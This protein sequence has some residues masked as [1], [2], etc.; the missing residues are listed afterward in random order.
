MVAESSSRTHSTATNKPKEEEEE[1]ETIDDVKISDLL[2]LELMNAEIIPPSPNRSDSAF[3]WLPDFVGFSWIAYG[4]SSLL[5]ISHLP[6]P[7][8]KEESL[9]RPFFRQVVELSSDESVLVKAV[10]WSPSF[11]SNG[12]LAAVVENCV[13]LYSENSRITDGSFRWVHVGILLHS[14]TVDTIKW[15]G[16]GDGIIAVGVDVAMWKRNSQTWEIVWKFKEELPQ[17]LVSTTWSIEG[18]A[19]TAAY[20]GA[21]SNEDSSSLPYGASKCVLVFQNDEKH[22]AVRAELHHPQPVS[23]IQ[24]RP[25][26]RTLSKKDILHSEKD[27]LLTCCLDGTVRL[28]SEIDSGRAKKS[29]KDA[30]D[31]KHIRRSFH[32]TAVIEIN[33]LLNGTLGRDI[34]VTW[35]VELRGLINTDEGAKQ[36][37]SSGKENNQPGKCEWLIGFGPGI[38]LSFWAIHCL[39]DISP[40]RFPRVILWKRQLLVGTEVSHLHCP[41]HSNA[42][43]LPLFTKAVT[44]R[45]HFCGP[46]VICSLVQLLPCNSASWLQLFTPPST[47]MD[48]GSLEWSGKEK[49]L[50]CSACGVLCLDG[51]SGRILQIALH[52]Y[53]CELELAV[54]LDSN[55]VLLFWSLSTISSCSLGMAMVGHHS[56]K[57]VG[58]TLIQN[59]SCFDY[60][61]LRWAPSVLNEYRVLLMGHSKGIDCFIIK[62]SGSEEEKIL[63]HRLCTIP[64]FGHSRSDAPTNI[65]AI[66]FP[67]DCG[68][69]FMFDNFLLVGVW[70]KEFQALSWKVT[71]LCK[72]L[73]ESSCDCSFDTKNGAWIYENDFDGKRYYVVAAPCSSKLPDPH[74]HDQVMSVA[75]VC[76]GTLMPYVQQNWSSPTG[77]C[78]QYAAYHMATGCLDGSLKLWR[79]GP[80]T[81]TTPNLEWAFS[82]WE[83]VGM[84]YVHPG[85]INALS[86]SNCGR[87]VATI[88]KASHSDNVSTLHIWDSVC[89]IG[90]GNFLAEDNICLDGDVIALNWLALGNGQLLLGVCMQNELRVYA[91]KRCGRHSLVKSGKSLDMH[92]WFC[93]ASARTSPA[94]EG[95]LWGPRATPIIVHEKYFCHFSQWSFHVDKKYRAKCHRKCSEDNPHHCQDGEDTGMLSAIFTDCG[96]CNVEELSIDER[97]EGCN[98]LFPG[99]KSVTIDYLFNNYFLTMAKQQYSLTSK[100]GWWNMLEVAKKLSGSLPIYN[101]EALLLNIYSGKWKHAYIAIRHL[102]GYLKSDNASVTCQNGN[103]HTRPSHII[104]QIHL[105]KYFEELFSTSLGDKGFQWGGDASVVSSSVQFEKSPT[106]F[107]GYY[108]TVNSTNDMFTYPSAKSEINS[109]IET[110]EKC[111]DSVG[112]NDIEKIQMLALID[113]LGEISGSCSSA[114]DSLD[115][116]GQRFWV[117]LRFQQ[118]Y[119]LRRFGRPASAEDLVVDSGLIGWAFHSDCQENLFSSCLSNEPSWQEMRNLGVG[120]WFTNSTELRTRME[121]LARIQYLK[122]KDPKDCALLYVALNRLQ[123]LA[124]LFKISRD[125]RDKPMVGF[126][127]RNFQEEKNKAAALKNAYVL[128]GKHQMEL[129]IA[130]FLLGGEPSS[131]VTICAKNL[132]DE[133]LALVICRLLEGFGGPLECHLTSTFLLPAAFEKQDYW[134]SSLLEWTLGNYPQSFLSLLGFKT[135]LALNKSNLLSNYAAFLDPN[136]GH[137]CLMLTS[138]RRMRNSVGENVAAKLARWATWMTANALNRCGLPLEALEWLSS[139]SSTPEDKDEGSVD[140]GNL[141]ILHRLLKSSTNDAS[142]WL[143][144]DVAFHLES[145]AKLDLAIQY[146]SGLIMEHP[147]WQD[148][149]LRSNQALAHPREYEAHQFKL[150]HE[151]F[152]LKLNTGLAIFEQKYA[153]NTLDLIKMML[154]FSGN[155]GLPFL[156]YQILHG[157]TSQG[158]QQDDFNNFLSFCIIPTLILKASVQVCY[159]VARNIMAWSIL[160]SQLTPSSSK[161]D[162]YGG[163]RSDELC[164]WNSYVT[165]PMRSLS[166]TLQIYCAGFQRDDFTVRIFTVLD[167]FEYYS[168]LSS[169]WSLKNLKGFILMIQPILIMYTNNEYTPSEADITNLKKVMYQSAELTTHGLL[170]D[171]VGGVPLATQGQNEQESM[172]SSIP[173]EERWP[174]LKA[175]LWRFLSKFAKVLLQPVVDVLEDGQVNNISLSKL[176]SLTFGSGSSLSDG[177]FAVKQINMVTLVLAEL[178][179]SS[180]SCVSSSHAKQLASFLWQKVDHGLPIHTLVWLEKSRSLPRP[181]GSQRDWKTYN[182]N[183]I[184]DTNWRVLFEILWE[185]S[186]LKEIRK[187]FAQENI[188]WLQFISLKSS[189][190]WTNIHKENIGDCENADTSSYDPAGQHSIS[191]NGAESSAQYQSLD[192]HT[193]LGPRWQTPTIIREAMC[194][195]HPKEVYKKNGELLEAICINSIDQRETALASNRKGITFFKWRGEKPFE[196]QSDYIWSEADWPQDGWA[197]SESTPIPLFV[198]P[199]VN[200]GKGSHLGFGGATISP[201]PLAKPG[202]E[203]TGGGAFGIPGYA[204]IG[205]SG[206]GWGVQE[207]FEEFVDPPATVEN[208]STRALSSHPTRPLFLVGSSNTHVY[209]WEFGK[210]RAIATY[211][212]FPAANV[213]LPYALASISALQFDHCGQR[214]ATAALDGTVSTWQLEVGGRSNVRPTESALCF[215]NHALDVSYVAGSGSIIAAAGYNSNGVNV[216]VWDT[217]AP[218]T[219]SQAS[220]TCHEGGARSLSVFDHDIGSGSISPLIVTGGKGGD[221]GVHDF[222]FIATGRTKRNRHSNASEQN[223]KSSPTHDRQSGTSNKFG[224]QNMNGMLWYIPKAHQGS[225]TRIST[226]PNTSLFLTGSKDGDVK[227]WDAKRAELV[228]HWPKLHEKHTFLQPNSRG[229]G[230]VVRAAVT[231]IQVLSDGFLTCGGDGTT[232]T[233]TAEVG[234]LAAYWLVGQRIV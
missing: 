100:I 97:S 121:K 120:F 118:F 37:F 192:G 198:S 220:L 84:F 215:N 81:S 208:I 66:P 38:S 12:D 202:K 2:P 181:Q 76:P 24:W 65:F 137:Y 108:S 200:L 231:D 195:E 217:L 225:V 150:L 5:V 232:L 27:V 104:P 35:A 74:N 139:S 50:S 71:L 79:S 174:F 177:N 111:N 168:C 131:A 207:D 29:G 209:L 229:F 102:V 60:M 182:L 11:P 204:G 41:D 206:L 167:L 119:F 49:C 28:W 128:L 183:E 77:M 123:V 80:A 210:D 16:S 134:L 156:G 94:I 178:L 22:G 58:K 170:S 127:S 63:C 85:P 171:D 172:W 17:A 130:F 163:T 214:F 133:Q 196:D 152:Q 165:R 228:F 30:T 14:S 98:S 161:S 70:T 159:L 191:S 190:S 116:P 157:Y 160:Y 176:S 43:K 179:K 39:D 197:G 20:L 82:P 64:F 223:T 106:Q 221:V 40:L 46:P 52:P 164:A 149:C 125:E 151:S 148:I 141:D 180:L 56:W 55:G 153:L 19:A 23:M 162:G 147:V 99:L 73:S 212:V 110:L 222:R 31:Q 213:P 67:S 8:S 48:D 42:K 75:V 122:K 18:P 126:L 114:Y 224:E 53:S 33:Q 36:Y 109:F 145:H 57:Q 44:V 93:L 26:I 45:S 95:F 21:S 59:F 89:F 69:T 216:V 51:H 140:F 219:T 62:I 47:D 135:D 32:V 169:A 112:M 9:I 194:F 13:C 143:L 90:S 3:D 91:Q 173:E 142:N 117:G 83:L 7:L 1:E 132:G 103:C 234:L 193:F 166:A 187:G 184:N 146:L 186:D 185:I 226:I 115:E 88:S 68:Q 4:A 61:S 87:K 78:R 189:R 233:Q 10:A 155:H 136:V 86:F 72:D 211:G 201:K 105:S 199:D 34:F 129:A 92:I 6:S 227:L 15:T 203:I 158:L 138:K 96:S 154:E 124:G 188:S 54:S 144:G 205:A 230:G 101:P 175:W 25:S 107:G 218:S 113:L